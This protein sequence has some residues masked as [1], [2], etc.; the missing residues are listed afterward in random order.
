MPGCPNN[1]DNSRIGST[2]LAAES[3]G[4][5]CLDIFLSPTISFSLSISFR[6]TARNQSIN[7]PIDL[8]YLSI[9]RRT[10]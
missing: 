9:V 4:K 1:L 10:T 6:V 8:V 7:Q 3:A 2:V 5:A